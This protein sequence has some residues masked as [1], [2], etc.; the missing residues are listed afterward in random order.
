MDR[1][2]RKINRKIENLRNEMVLTFIQAGA[3]LN[4]P[5][6][7]HLSQLLDEQLNRYDR[8]VRKRFSGKLLNMC[9]FP[10]ITLIKRFK[11][12]SL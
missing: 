12:F 1:E 10:I 9:L 4:N 6:V 11:K 5:D 8:H 3:E 2:L 7:I